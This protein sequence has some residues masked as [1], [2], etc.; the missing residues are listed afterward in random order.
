MAINKL[1][2]WDGR[3]QQ[4]HSTLTHCTPHVSVDRPSVSTLR[5]PLRLPA[6]LA[7]MRPLRRA[8]VNTGIARA[9]ALHSIGEQALADTLVHHTRLA[10]SSHRQTGKPL[11]LHPSV[12]LRL[13]GPPVQRAQRP[14]RE[15]RANESKSNAN[16]AQLWTP[17]RTA[18]AGV[19]RHNGQGKR[20]LHTL[21]HCLVLPFVL[22]Q[23]MSLSCFEAVQSRQGT[24]SDVTY[25]P[26]SRYAILKYYSLQP[27]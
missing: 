2:D 8:P 19:E 17:I 23:G 4:G 10:L 3:R 13:A 9:V 21:T 11:P 18:T 14:S 7:C 27:T 15:A 1:G 20:G 22:L 6:M 24:S 16:C 12:P 26:F 5:S 25:K